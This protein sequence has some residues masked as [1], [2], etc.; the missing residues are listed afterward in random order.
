MNGHTTEAVAAVPPMRNVPPALPGAEIVAVADNVI[1]L[2][3]VFNRLRSRFLSA[4]QRDVDWSAHVL[5]AALAAEGPMRAGALAEAVHSD[6]STVSRQIAPIIKEGYVERRA[7]Q[8]DGRASVLAVTPKGEGLVADHRK[9][10]YAHYARIL[11]G[12][13]ES[14]CAEFARLLARFAT[15]L[16]RDRVDWF[17][18]LSERGHQ[19]QTPAAGD[20]E[21]GYERS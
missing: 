4:V 2:T 14:E 20:G 18:A 6:P 17:D 11:D 8:Q 3:R 5:I 10:L 12:W 16:D 1:R 9:V 7:D 13:S 15:D 19:P 21:A